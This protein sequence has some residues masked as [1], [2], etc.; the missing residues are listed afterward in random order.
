[1]FAEYIFMN[2]LIAFPASILLVAGAFLGSYFWMRLVSPDIRSIFATKNL[3]WSKNPASV[4]FCRFSLRIEYFLHKYYSLGFNNQLISYDVIRLI[5]YVFS[6]P[7]KNLSFLNQVQTQIQFN[8]HQN[9]ATY[10]RKNFQIGNRDPRR[11]GAPDRP[12]SDRGR[13][14]P[15]PGE[16]GRGPN[17]SRTEARLDMDPNTTTHS[18]H[19]VLLI[20]DAGS[21]YGK[22]IDRR[23]RE[24]GV[25][26]E[27][28]PL[29]TTP[30]FIRDNA[31]YKAIIISGGPQSVYESDAP[32]FDPAILGLGLPILGICYGMQLL[33][34]HSGNKV[35]KKTHREDGQFEIQVRI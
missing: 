3:Y 1:M 25:E 23:I 22:V 29:E 26:T 21:Q 4:V 2:R 30:A 8:Y 32:R 31:K 5:L 10:S 11:G 35:E 7:A 24:L 33:S 20:L 15:N 16:R 14:Q 13:N 17:P 28:L 27:L 34:F 9:N 18:H 12:H 6:R 19:Q